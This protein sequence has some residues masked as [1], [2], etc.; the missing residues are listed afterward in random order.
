MNSSTRIFCAGLGLLVPFTGVHAQ[1]EDP[2]R[3][4]LSIRPALQLAYDSNVFRVNRRIVGG[5][6]EGDVR[7][8]PGLD[9]DISLPIGRQRVFLSG[10][11]G[12]DFYASNSRLDRERIL[13]DGGA[14]LRVVGSC[15]TA[16]NASLAR[17]QG[18][19]ANGLSLFSLP[20]TEERT[21]I[22]ADVT[23]GRNPGLQPSVGY[24]HQRVKNSNRSFNRTNS[25]S[26]SFRASL[27]FARPTFGALSVYGTHS[28]ARYDDRIPLAPGI[29]AG[30]REGI[31]TYGVGIRYQREIGARLRGTISAGYTWV[32]PKL[33]GPRFRGADYSAG[34]NYRASERLAINLDARR[35]AELPNLINAL[36][37]ITDSVQLSATYRL[38]PRVSLN[39][40]SSYQYRKLKS[41]EIFV[42]Q[43]LFATRD[44][45]LLLNAGAG[46]DVGQRLRLNLGFTHQQRR[47]DNDLFRYNANQIVF[48]ASYEL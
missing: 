18:D 9:V 34:V 42:G 35:R 8:S 45:L 17:L 10:F 27:A 40:G 15:L 4:E 39:L 44:E 33:G 48:G 30:L 14:D 37:A 5:P 21:A 6:D 24:T 16:I 12:Y 19:L 28:N 36:Y 20:N 31:E 26:D 41:S 3:R 47:S 2:D 23:C 25:T 11:A 46:Y 38:N 7:I 29:P 1:W 22:G 32:N 43:P 13:L